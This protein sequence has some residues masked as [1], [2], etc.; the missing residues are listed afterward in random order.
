V[1][2]LGVDEREGKGRKVMRHFKLHLIFLFS[3]QIFQKRRDIKRMERMTR[4][5]KKEEMG[6]KKGFTPFSN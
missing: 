6:E 3:L 2:S 1:R 5:K 4:K